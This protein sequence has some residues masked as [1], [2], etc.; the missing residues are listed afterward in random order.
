[1]NLICVFKYL[2]TTRLKFYNSDKYHLKH[3]QLYGFLPMHKK[4]ALTFKIS[5]DHWYSFSPVLQRGKLRGREIT[6][7]GDRT[8]R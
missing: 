3:K 4:S 6:S 7:Q 8:G 5:T 1:M 2:I